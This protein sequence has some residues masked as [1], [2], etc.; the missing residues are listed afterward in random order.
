MTSI[1]SQLDPRWKDINLPN[2]TGSITIGNYGCLLCCITNLLNKESPLE[3]MKGNEDCWLKDGNCKTDLLLSRFGYKLVREPLTEGQKLP[4]KPFR[5]IMRT[6]WFS[7]RFPTHFFIQEANST[8]I[9]DPA[10]RYNPKKEN[11][12]ALKVNEIRYLVP[13]NNTTEKKVC[14]ACNRPF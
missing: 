2:C 1:V 8:D 6:S 12:Y 13:L 3:V 4:L 11:R 9:I 14:T 10:S 5:T 7:P